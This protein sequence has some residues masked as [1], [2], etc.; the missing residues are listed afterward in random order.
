MTTFNTGAYPPGCT[1]ADVDRAQ[2]D[3]EPPYEP[4][5]EEQE[6]DA[7]EHWHQRATKLEKENHELKAELERVRAGLRRVELYNKT[8]EEHSLAYKLRAALGFNDKCSLSRLDEEAA[9][10]RAALVACVPLIDAALAAAGEDRLGY[11]G[12]ADIESQE[13]VTVTITTTLGALRKARWRLWLVN[14]LERT[15]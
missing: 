5:R 15:S 9:R 2:R 12:N 6:A 4:T 14:N 7:W 8:A 11:I 10:Q 13:P 1:Q 3:D